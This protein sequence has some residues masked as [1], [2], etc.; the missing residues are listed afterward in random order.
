MNNAIRAV[1]LLLGMAGA[2]SAQ[3]GA[4]AG[5]VPAGINYQGRLIDAGSP[6]SGSRSMTFRLFDAAA[7]G[8]A[9]WTG[10]P[11]TVAVSSG[12]FSTT[13]AM[14][15][16]A[17]SGP[18][19]KYLEVE[20]D[21][22]KLSPRE[23][24]NA[25]PYALVAK[26]VEAAVPGPACGNPA[27]PADVMVP[28][29]DLCVDK[30]EASVWSAPFGGTQYGVNWATDYPC[31]NGATGTGQT[32]ASPGTSIFARSV[33]GVTPS[34]YLTWFQANIACANAGKHLLTNAEWQAA[35]T[36]TPDPGSLAQ[37][38]GPACNTNGTRAMTTGRGTSCVSSFGVENMIGSVMEWVADWGQ[39]GMLSP[40]GAAAWT[41]GAETNQHLPAAYNGD[42]SYNVAGASN[43]AASWHD[44]LPAALN[45]GGNWNSGVLAGVFELTANHGPSWA[46][47]SL[48]FRCGR[49]R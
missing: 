39:Y 8:A 3:Q 30:Y 23:P 14:T 19:Q 27:D 12:I 4:P 9:L 48:G 36:G 46:A 37:D 10:G 24:L 11:Q 43:D 17:L 1:V 6:V 41:P 38:D 34:T 47:G 42:G 25:V 49:R 13:L 31:G 33:A 2:A 29:G 16:Q 5:T 20:I 40:A 28:V 15:P 35:A 21:G 26:S 22:T 45:R 44:G 7:G 32:C 18:L